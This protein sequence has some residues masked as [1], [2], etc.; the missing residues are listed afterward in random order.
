MNKIKKKYRNTWSSQ[1]L[2]CD[3]E[4]IAHKYQERGRE[5][6][7]QLTKS[8]EDFFLGVLVQMFWTCTN[9]YRSKSIFKNG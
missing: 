8:L 7:K 9:T 2:S 5:S 6:M 3:I 1:R 4:K